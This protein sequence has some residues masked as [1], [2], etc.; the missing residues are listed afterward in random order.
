LVKHISTTGQQK[1]SI[2]FEKGNN[3]R[4]FFYFCFTLNAMNKKQLTYLITA[5][6]LVF[7]CNVKPKKISQRIN[8]I[9]VLEP[10]YSEV[11]IPANIAPLNFYVEE[12]GD[13]FY[14]EAKGQNGATVSVFS[15]D[16]DFRFREKKW[17]K[18]LEQNKNGMLNYTVY[19]ER[20]G[21]WL[22]FESFSQTVT[23][24]LVDPFLYYRLLHP[25]YESW[26]EISIMQR[27]LESFKERAVVENNVLD[28][29]CV[30]CHA[31]N[32]QN[33]DDFMLHVRGSHGGTYFLEGENLVNVN[34]KTEGNENGATYPRWHPSGRFVAFSS[35]KVVQQFHSSASKKIEVSDLNSKLVLYDREQNEIMDIDLQNSVQFMDTY[36]EWSPDGQHLYFC[37][38][39]QIG[40]EYDYRDI[41]YDLYRVKF[42][43]ETRKFGVAK[44]VFKASEMDK[45]V[46][47]PRISPDG[48]SLVFTLHD[49]GCFPIWHKEAD[50]YS[51]NLV[52]F[53]VKKLPVNSDFTES[54]HSWSSS[55]RWL[56]FSSKRGDGLSA[57]PY[58]AHVSETG[59]VDKP[60]VLPQKDP[61][62]YEKFVK[63]YNIPE[64]STSEVS[65]SPGKLRKTATSEPVQVKWTNQ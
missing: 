42:N 37:R 44:P 34:L 60:F 21:E 64:F 12:T 45:S 4:C 50:L 58:M 20:E 30:N 57:R 65:F 53:E 27:N 10:D 52:D 2:F 56:L 26:T 47:F 40:K 28:Q 29:N 46:S 43:S 54:Y 51:I 61:R 19:A 32:Q 33:P 31:F 62:F 49:Y 7:S 18:L 6:F 15:N 17:K 59:E 38:A 23:T 11:T 41:Q 3:P 22:Q 8:H 63:T 36:P 16:G 48:I 55:G 39:E 13:R 35:N 25:G 24:D 14:L 1:E 9:P 5:V